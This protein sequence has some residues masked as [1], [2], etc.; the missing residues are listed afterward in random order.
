MVVKIKMSKFRFFTNIFILFIL[1]FTLFSNSIFA[2]VSDS[3]T[4]NSVCSG[5]KTNVKDSLFL[6]MITLCLPGVLEK[7][8]TWKEIKCSAVTCKYDAI[9]AGIDPSF[10]DIQEKYSVCKL[11]VG[12]SFAVSGA[13]IFDYYR[14]MI[15]D[16]WANPQGILISAGTKYLRKSVNSNCAIPNSCTFGTNPLY[17]TQTVALV[18]I[19]TASLAQQIENLNTDSYLGSGVKLESSC[20]RIDKIQKEME[21]IIKFG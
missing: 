7:V 19:D 21:D 8:N 5:S 16:I 11:V 9:K 18:I 10:C 4:I 15:S 1:I 3:N 6:S 2:G 17:A 12:E 13:G 20:S 14:K